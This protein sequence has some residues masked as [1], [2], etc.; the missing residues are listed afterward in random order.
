MRLIS[1]RLPLGAALLLSACS[2]PDQ[3]VAAQTATA[4]AT[5]AA[6]APTASASA[7]AS[8][9]SGGAVMVES[10][11]GALA[12]SYKHPAEVGAVPELAAM[13]RAEADTSR[14]EAQ[15]MALEDRASARTDGYSFNPHS[16]GVE[17]Q[18][19]TQTPRFLS[20]SSSFYTFTGGA[21]GNYG[22]QGLVWDRE[23]VARLAATDLF[24]SKAALKAAV[25]KPF[26]TALDDERRKKGIEKPEEE[27][28]FPRCVDPVGEATIVLGSTSRRKFDRIGFLMDPYVA[29]SYAEGSYEVTLPVTAAI[30]AAVRPE[31]RADFAVR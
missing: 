11:N 7:T 26:C 8:A 5:A 29:G 17:W 24:V 27:S 9:T 16:L 28:V 19:V 25:L 20:L 22:F 23:K 1:M 21:H 30:L 15:R 12:F 18:V 6:P 3:P 31:Y 14:T 10:D 2:S 13:L 4:S